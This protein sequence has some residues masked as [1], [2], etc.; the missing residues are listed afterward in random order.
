MILNQEKNIC[1]VLA[2]CSIRYHSVDQPLLSH[3]TDP[4]TILFCNMHLVVVIHA[5]VSVDE[6]SL[7]EKAVYFV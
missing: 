1:S 2:E 5:M 4:G 7:S 3:D 6:V